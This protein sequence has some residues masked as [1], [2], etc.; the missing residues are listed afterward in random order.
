MNTDDIR[1]LITEMRCS[2]DY[3]RPDKMQL[4]A[5]IDILLPVQECGKHLREQGGW[6]DSELADLI[7]EADRRLKDL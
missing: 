7:D 1:A 6:I 4:A 2:D 5:I 3:F